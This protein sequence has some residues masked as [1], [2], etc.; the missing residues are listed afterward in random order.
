MLLVQ[1]HRGC[2][3]GNQG[4]EGQ[5]RMKLLIALLSRF[6]EKIGLHLT[7]A[8]ILLFHFE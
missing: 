3:P 2:S 4:T 7:F 8:A 1:R 6:F 5:R